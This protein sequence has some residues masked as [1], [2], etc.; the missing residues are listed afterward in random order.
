MSFIGFLQKSILSRLIPHFSKYFIV[1]LIW[2]LLAIFLVWVFID[3]FH[4]PTVLVSFL[5]VA[6]LFVGKYI[7]YR[8]INLVHKKFFT[9]ASVVIWTSLGNIFLMWLLVDI[10]G[11]SGALSQTF[12]AGFI[13]LLRFSG[14]YSTGLS[15]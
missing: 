7:T 1:G 15:K 3:R 13:F 9:Y 5:V 14:F 12:I 8:K 10:I 6:T 2:N 4:F 11:W